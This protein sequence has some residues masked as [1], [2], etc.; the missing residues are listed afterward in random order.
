ML[1][2]MSAFLGR[3]KGQVR[4]VIACAKNAGAHVLCLQEVMDYE[5][6]HLHNA[7]RF[8]RFVPMTMFADHSRMGLVTCTNLPVTEERVQYY[9]GNATKIPLFDESTPERVNA[10]KRRPLLTCDVLHKGESRRVGN[11][12]FLYS[13]DGTASEQHHTALRTFIEVARLTSPMILCGAMVMPRGRPLYE[14]IM[15][16]SDFEDWVPPTI[17]CT[18]DPELHKLSARLKNG[19][20]PPVVVDYIFGVGWDFLPSS[21]IVQQFRGVSDHTPL[22]ATVP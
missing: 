1:K 20:V 2:I 3:G 14:E 7:Y 15:K 22:L 17:T 21:G 18:L 12:H 11:T 8:V 16:N 10:T 13:K 9:V 5:L 4:G 6:R 19:E